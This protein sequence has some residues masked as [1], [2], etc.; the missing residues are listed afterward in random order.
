MHMHSVT[1]GV[2]LMLLGCAAL[3]H[4]TSAP[5]PVSM[6]VWRRTRPA[7]STSQRLALAAG[8]AIP[9][10][11]NIPTYGEYVLAIHYFSDS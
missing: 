9:V 7:L 8:N 4:A 2:L 10:K 3:V 1:A 11:G 6:P 5:T